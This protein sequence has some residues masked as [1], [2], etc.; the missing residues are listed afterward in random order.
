MNDETRRNHKRSEMKQMLA[1]MKKE[2]RLDSTIR[3]QKMFSFIEHLYDELEQ[4]KVESVSS[5]KESN[6]Q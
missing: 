5:N 6:E 2:L 4:L 1:E 3:Q